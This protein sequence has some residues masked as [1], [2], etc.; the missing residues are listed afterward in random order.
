MKMR[1]PPS[2][3]PIKG[4]M[5]LRKKEV[6]IINYYLSNAVKNSHLIGGVRDF[7]A[8]T[9]DNS[10]E[11]FGMDLAHI[12]D[13]F[14]CA[15][16]CPTRKYERY[17][18]YDST[19]RIKNR[20]KLLVRGFKT[21]REILEH[22]GIVDITVPG[23]DRFIDMVFD[24]FKMQPYAR[25][26]LRYIIYCEIIPMMYS[27]DIK[28][29]GNNKLKS[30]RNIRRYSA[31]TGAPL[32]AL[33]KL[34][35]SESE[36]VRS[37]ILLRDKNGDVALSDL[38]C[39]MV[40]SKPTNDMMLKKL[41]FGKAAAASLA[42]NNFSHIADE[43]GYICTTLGNAVKNHEKGVNFLIYGG[44]GTGKTELCKSIAKDIGVN[45]Y[46]NAADNKQ[47]RFGKLA[48][49]ETLLADEKDVVI[50]FDEAEDVFTKNKYVEDNLSKLT[51]NRFLE[52]NRVPIIWISNNISP[53]D[54]AYIRRFQYALEVRKPDQSAKEEIWKNICA[55]RKVKIAGDKISTLARTYDIPPSFIDTAVKAVKLA[56]SD[57]AIERT[58][59]ALQKASHGY[60]PRKNNA[61]E[62]DFA[63]ELLNTDIDLNN[64]A[65]KLSAKGDLRFSL[66]LYG[67]PGTGKSAFARYLAERM[68]LKV[69]QKRASDLI[70]CWVG[71]TEKNIARAFEEARDAKSMLVFDEADTFLRSRQMAQRGWEVSQVNEM[72]TQM[73]NHQFPFV[74]TTNLMKDLDE[75]SLRRFTF[76]VKHGFLKSSQ[77]AVAFKRFFD[78]D[79][80][81]SSLAHLTH[82]TPGDFAVVRSKQSFLDV[83]D[84]ME[85]AKLLEEE[86]RAK[87]IKAGRMGFG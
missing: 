1:V 23:Y 53:M 17:S 69:I 42:S 27:F 70:S 29:F 18:R 31:I 64:L 68:D 22:R 44:P 19:E 58:I 83:S 41:L 71:E 55:K 33:E 78:I 87:G 54:S 79:G 73:E 46:M 49:T 21:I 14:G 47:E 75:A 62:I 52:N 57:N 38:F 86:Q 32:A 5:L 59:D 36:L 13:D 40:R 39:S 10:A 8:W 48:I 82:L 60:A 26:F 81:A 61:G 56:G 35:G 9:E 65:E 12:W 4:A 6:Q 43:Y 16:Y 3:V 80:D 30:I 85:L 34:F 63:P 45:L 15:S 28:I 66:C 76:K 67:E 51:L 84:S 50:L 11:L 20:D 25:A 74:C 2:N 77:L 37:G 24:V 7:I 72:L